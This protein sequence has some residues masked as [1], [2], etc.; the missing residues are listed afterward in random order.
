MD[1]DE[2]YACCGC[3]GEPTGSISGKHGEAYHCGKDT[4]VTAAGEML[5]KLLSYVQAEVD[6]K[7]NP[8]A[9]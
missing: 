6:L 2:K 3:G 5:A 1:D 8:K 7:L 4:C 9:H